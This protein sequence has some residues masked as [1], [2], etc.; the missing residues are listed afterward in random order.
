[1]ASSS[2]TRESTRVV[3]LGRLKFSPPQISSTNCKLAIPW[4]MANSSTPPT[5][6]G[7]ARFGFELVQH[8]CRQ[9]GCEL[10]VLNTEK[11]SPQARNGARLDGDHAL[12][13]VPE[14]LIHQESGHLLS[15]EPDSTRF[16]GALDGYFGS[17]PL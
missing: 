16:G 3:N 1:M 12:F 5:R 8:L 4:A 2:T 14:R 9:H 7:L 11:V 17:K 15:V 13:F 10:L 6:T